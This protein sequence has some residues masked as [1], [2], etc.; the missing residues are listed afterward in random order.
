MS[1]T[2]LITAGVVC[3]LVGWTLLVLMVLRTIPP[4]FAL[5]LG[6]YTL[7]LGGLVMGLAGLLQAG[8]SQ[9]M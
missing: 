1:P 6:A 9:R 4:S 5:A 3:L 8:R 2:T 7:S